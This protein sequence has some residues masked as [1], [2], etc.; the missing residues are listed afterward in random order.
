[1]EWKSIAII[2]SET[3]KLDYYSEFNFARAV[4]LT[5][6]MREIES[7]YANDF[8][9]ITACPLILVNRDLSKEEWIETFTLGL[10]VK[11]A[12][13]DMEY[14]F[15]MDRNPF[16]SAYIVKSYRV[17]SS[18]KMYEYA[19]EMN[20]MLYK[21]V[22]FNAN[23]KTIAQLVKNFHK[24]FTHVIKRNSSMYLEE[25]PAYARELK[26]TIYKH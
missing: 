8:K 18:T 1:M 9:I 6:F 10:W 25:I 19:G 16:F 5:K 15:E 13:V 17:D 14:Y 23:E 20:D 11:F 4:A 26:Q 2:Q 22:N 24:A 21:N 7:K 12:I 3:T